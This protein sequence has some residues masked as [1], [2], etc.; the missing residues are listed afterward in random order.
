MV[1]PFME[2]ISFFNSSAFFLSAGHTVRLTSGSEIKW[3]SRKQKVSYV[4][5]KEESWPLENK[6]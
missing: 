3:G 6:T 4:S 1:I 5:L 2:E